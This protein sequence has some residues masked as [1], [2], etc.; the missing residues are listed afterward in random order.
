MGKAEI[1]WYYLRSLKIVRQ[2]SYFKEHSEK[3]IQ[4]PHGKYIYRCRV[5][6]YVHIYSVNIKEEKILRDHYNYR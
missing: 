6:H 4:E 5:K 1:K 2:S 3:N